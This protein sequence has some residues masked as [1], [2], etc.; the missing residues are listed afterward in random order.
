[1]IKGMEISIAPHIRDCQMSSL[2]RRYYSL[3]SWRPLKG[4]KMI[5]LVRLRTVLENTPVEVTKKP[6][7]KKIGDKLH[8]FGYQKEVNWWSTTVDF[9]E[10]YERVSGIELQ[11]GNRVLSGGGIFDEG[12]LVGVHQNGCSWKTERRHSSHPAQ[13]NGSRT[14]CRNFK[15]E[16]KQTWKRKKNRWRKTKRGINRSWTWNP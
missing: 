3:G 9:A 12:K 5:W 6:V 15:C 11:G 4:F 14:T 7:V 10:S 13:L 2:A 16:T 8:V 1:M